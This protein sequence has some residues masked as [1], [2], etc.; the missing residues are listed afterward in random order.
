LAHLTYYLANSSKARAQWPVPSTFHNMISTDLRT[1]YTS[2]CRNKCPPPEVLLHTHRLWQKV[3]KR[4]REKR[5]K[6]LT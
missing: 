1:K 5:R 6:C 4:E 3:R 2:F